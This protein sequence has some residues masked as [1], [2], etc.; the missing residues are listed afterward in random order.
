MFAKN[1]GSRMWRY[2]LILTLL[3]G[4]LI[5][6]SGSVRADSQVINPALPETFDWPSWWS[7]SVGTNDCDASWYNANKTEGDDA[8]LQTSWRGIQSCGPHPG[9][10]GNATP[11]FPNSAYD[12]EMFQCTEL[13]ARYL[14]VAYGIPSYQG[15]GSDFAVSYKNHYPNNFQYFENVSGSGV[16][17]QEG[18]VVSMSSSSSAGH[19]AIVTELVSSDTPGDGYIVLMDQNGS[20]NGTFTLQIS[21]YQIQSTSE[22]GDFTWIHPIIIEVLTESSPTNSYATNLYGVT[23]DQSQAWVVGEEK[24]AGSS[25][26]TVTWNWSGGSWTKFNPPTVTGST[27]H[28]YLHDVTIDGSG[29]IWTVGEYDCGYCN[30]AYRWYTL[31]FEWN[32]STQAWVRKTSDSFT[33]STNNY[34]NAVGAAGTNVYA[35]G[36]A[37]FTSPNHNQPLLLKWNGT[38]FEDQSLAFPTGVTSATLTDISFS[39]ATNGWIVGDVGPL[40]AEYAYHF[41]GSTWTPV[42][43][44]ATARIQKVVTLSD[45]EAWGIGRYVLNSVL[46][47]HVFHY[48]TANSWQE[49]T[50]ITYPPSNA[51]IYNIDA[52][53]SN[54]VWIVGSYIPS[55][56]L[57]QAFMLRYDG[58]GWQPVSTPTQTYLNSMRDV[59]VN[60]GKVW[61]AGV[62]TI[63]LA[64]PYV[65]TK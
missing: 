40:D 46:G 20:A 53:A 45:D 56:T 48:T 50:G 27:H 4:S 51:A 28:H 3:I 42:A 54:N 41:D 12:K 5:P 52:D 7:G 32:P 16:F 29:N 39:S 25:S 65:L 18:D 43:L 57:N 36:Y 58:V 63:S 33:T 26:R 19:V 9:E 31:A 23:S 35:V 21:N 6:I 59:S 60:S 13:A 17:P 14:Q 34:V 30:G 2:A 64:Y 44:P 61:S 62:K 1:N 49:V 8:I 22:F 24:P 10:S 37:T 55:G 47:N 15:S 11:D 38:K